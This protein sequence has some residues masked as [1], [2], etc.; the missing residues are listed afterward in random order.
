MVP[1]KAS[2]LKR[3]YTK[4]RPAS[5]PEA[6]PF[7]ASRLVHIHEMVW[8]KFREIIQ[9]SSLEAPYCAPELYGG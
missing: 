3:S 8:P 4:R 7:V 5:S 9:G 6:D 2:N 1:V